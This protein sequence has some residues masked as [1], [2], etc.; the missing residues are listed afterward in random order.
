LAYVLRN[1]LDK[2]LY[3]LSNLLLSQV[4]IYFLAIIFA[5]TLAALVKLNGTLLKKSSLLLLFVFLYLSF[6]WRTTFGYKIFPS[7]GFLMAMAV[8]LAGSRLPHFQPNI[9][10]VGIFSE[11]FGYFSYPIAALSVFLVLKW[12]LVGLNPFWSNA[13]I[14]TLNAPLSAN[15]RCLTSDV[16]GPQFFLEHDVHPC[17]GLFPSL[18]PPFFEVM[19]TRELLSEQLKEGLI[20][21]NRH[22]HDMTPWVNEQLNEVYQGLTCIKFTEVSS[23]CYQEK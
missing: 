3:P 15:C 22:S 20:A 9:R 6:F 10:F 12:N 23:V 7:I 4:T 2:P 19:T 11:R 16:W 5:F 17:P 18:P 13:G 1:L 8:F 21:I 14:C